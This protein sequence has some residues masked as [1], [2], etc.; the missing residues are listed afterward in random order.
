MVCIWSRITKTIQG[1]LLIRAL[2]PLFS[3][4]VCIVHTLL[5]KTDVDLSSLNT[6]SGCDSGAPSLCE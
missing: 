3:K 1:A 2:E 6:F 4:E 5:N